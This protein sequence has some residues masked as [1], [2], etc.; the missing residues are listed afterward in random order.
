[1][2][3]P[4]LENDLIS[5]AKQR[6]QSVFNR[7]YQPLIQ[8]IKWQLSTK[9]GNQTCK[10]FDDIQQLCLL[11]IFKELHYYKPN[12]G[13]TAISFARMLINQEINKQA[14]INMKRDSVLDEYD[15]DSDTRQYDTTYDDMV[16]DIKD[17]LIQ[18]SSIIP[19]E[20]KTLMD[21]LIDC[22]QTIDIGELTYKQKVNYLSQRSGESKCLVIKFLAHIRQSKINLVS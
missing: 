1:M 17:R 6:K 3:S 9:Y 22:V 8:I 5:Y 11:R 21:T 4:T 10:H 2:H 13:M 14:L 19:V 15:I 18:Y 12:K 20:Y 7:I 16:K